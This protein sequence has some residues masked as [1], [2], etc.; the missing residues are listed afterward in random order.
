M[1][2]AVSASD[3]AEADEAPITKPSRQIDQPL[4]ARKRCWAPLTQ[5][6]SSD[7]R[8]TRWICLLNAQ[9][10]WIWSLQTRSASFPSWSASS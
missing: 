5:A 4:N 6:C 10:C 2:N 8:P 1:E 3:S 7:Q 9:I